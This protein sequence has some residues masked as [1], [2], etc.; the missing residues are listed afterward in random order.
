MF[1]ESKPNP[2]ILKFSG[3]QNAKCYISQIMQKIRN[4]LSNDYVQFYDLSLTILTLLTPFLF[5]F[6]DLDYMK[7]EALSDIFEDTE[8]WQKKGLNC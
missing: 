8:K 7:Y 2:I 5:V 4:L 3:Y 6:A 1:V